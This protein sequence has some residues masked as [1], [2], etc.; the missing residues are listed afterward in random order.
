[1]LSSRVCDPEGVAPLNQPPS[2]NEEQDDLRWQG[3]NE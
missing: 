1:M 2:T 3:L